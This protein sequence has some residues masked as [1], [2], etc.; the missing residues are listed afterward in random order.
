M[1]AAYTLLSFSLLGSAAHAAM[2]ITQ[3][4]NFS[5]IPAASQ[6]LTFNEFDTMGGTRTLLGV[7]ITT[8]VT[9]SGGSLYVDNESPMGAS[10]EI[11]Q[12]VT[13]SLSATRASL[14]LDDGDEE[15]FTSVG[16]NVKAT[17]NLFVTLDP[18]DGDNGSVPG[19]DEGGPDWGG[20]EFS[21]NVTVT[22]TESIDP[23]AISSYTYNGTGTTFLITVNGDQ[24]TNVSSVG[25]PSVTY[26]SAAASGYVTV[27]YNYVPEPGS[28]LIVCGGLGAG[29][30]VRRRRA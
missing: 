3:T 11:S 8:S 14:L 2:T 9:K 18:D 19:Y 25:G 16:Q 23:I 10:G 4:Q 30:F 28:W 20:D 13:I 29:M 27:T 6:I 15:T 5:F 22:R 7:T 24:N 26:T 17:S 1:K 12:F 21:D